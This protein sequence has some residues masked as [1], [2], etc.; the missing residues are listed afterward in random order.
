[1][2]ISLSINAPDRA[3]AERLVARA[4]LFL[5]SRAILHIDVGDGSYTPEAS[6]GEPKDWVAMHALIPS[7]FLEV[8]FMTLDWEDRLIPWLE[9]GAKRVIVQIDLLRDAWHLADIANRYGAS[10]M[11][12]IPPRVS[13]DYALAYQGI[14]REF[15]V[16]SVPPGRSG[17][18][19]DP[20]AL[21]KIVIL[22]AAFPDAILEVD[23]GVTPGVLRPAKAAGADIAVSASYVWNATDPKAAYDELQSI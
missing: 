6:W 8:H 2:M 1:M 10:V 15:Q 4:A 7:A 22:R 23:G 17:Q 12:S 19:F 5:P 20:A 13:A 16:L 18:A 11:I 3:S 21:A 9:A 14:F